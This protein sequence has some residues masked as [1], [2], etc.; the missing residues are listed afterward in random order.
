MTGGLVR[1]ISATDRLTSSYR[2]IV[3]S[4]TVLLRVE[5]SAGL[6]NLWPANS[7]ASICNHTHSYFNY[8][9]VSLSDDTSHFQ[10]LFYDNWQSRNIEQ[11][12][13][14]WIKITSGHRSTRF[15]SRKRIDKFYYGEG[16]AY[17]CV[18]WRQIKPRINV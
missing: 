9:C 5:R 16:L 12:N 13:K 4:S 15:H 18:T 11:N 17:D 1:V 2:A 14:R 6:W 3:L 10:H 8:S 7:S